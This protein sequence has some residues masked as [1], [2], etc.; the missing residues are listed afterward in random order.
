M[1][2]EIRCNRKALREAF[3][4]AAQFAP[5]KSPKEILQSVLV[6]ASGNTLTLMATDTETRATVTMNGELEI[7]GSGEVLLPASSFQSILRESSGESIEIVEDSSA[8]RIK[9][10]HG[11][12]RMPTATADEFPR[13]Q[14]EQWETFTTIPADAFRNMAR[15]TVLATED[16]TNARFTTG[17]VYIEAENGQIIAVSTDGRRM[18]VVP[19]T[20]TSI[21]DHRIGSPDNVSSGALVPEHALALMERSLGDSS[22]V[23]IAMFGNDF[24]IRTA[25]ATVATRTLDGRFPNWRMIQN[26]SKNSREAVEVPLALIP[27][28][29]HA[30]VRQAAVVAEKDLESKGLVF[31][32]SGDVLRLK[33]QSQNVGVSDVEL[34]ITAT[35][36]DMSIRLN[37]EFVGDFFKWI[38]GADASM[39]VDSPSLPV[40]FKAADGDWQY[41]VMPM[42][43]VAGKK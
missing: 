42:A 35:V 40:V 2:F 13:P 37:H 18:S 11:K 43:D 17:G 14:A 41:Y 26:Q 3:A 21:G 9:A 10:G 12:W 16:S 28:G 15:R 5:R 29:L 22:D 36:P 24:A 34:P 30:A 32:F 6:V 33:G 1:P 19:V 23:D 25:H 38:G 31:H 8:V 20:G 39:Y 7:I 4:I 27:G